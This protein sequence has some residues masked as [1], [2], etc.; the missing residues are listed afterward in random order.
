MVEVLKATGTYANPDWHAFPDEEARKEGL[1]VM[2]RMTSGSSH[3][4]LGTER[5]DAANC[6]KIAKEAGYKGLFSVEGARNNGPD[7]YAAVQAILD[8]VLANI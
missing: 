5:I 2:Y 3:C 4:R 1:P 7:P 8:F 6:V